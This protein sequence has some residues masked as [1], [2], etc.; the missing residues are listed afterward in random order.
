MLSAIRIV[1]EDTRLSV[2]RLGRYIGDKGPGIVLVIPFID[3]GVL[4][5]AGD[6]EKI[7]GW[8]KISDVVRGAG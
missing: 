4:K 5:K 1:Q 8:I 2:H 6:V 3:R 7:P